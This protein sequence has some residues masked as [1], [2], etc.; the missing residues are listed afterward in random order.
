MKRVLLWLIRAYQAIPGPWH[1][2]CRYEPT[3]SHYAAEAV[4]RYGAWRGT[5]LTVRRLLRCAPWGGSGYDPVPLEWPE[6][7]GRRGKH[8][9]IRRPGETAPEAGEDSDGVFLA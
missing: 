7:L 4:E 6:K 3:C 2:A 5:R 8:P 9:Q 1:A